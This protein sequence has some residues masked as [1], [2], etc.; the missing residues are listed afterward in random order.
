MRMKRPTKTN[1]KKVSAA[2]E[3]STALV[4]S[5]EIA[6]LIKRVVAIIEEAQTRVVRVVNST[7]VLAYWSIGREI[8]EFVQ[9]GSA[10]AEYG[11][12]VLEGLASRLRKRV[13]RGYSIRNL[14]NFRRFYQAFSD[15][16]PSIHDDR[17]FGRRRLPN[18]LTGSSSK[19]EIRQMPSAES[20]SMLTR[21]GFS[22][23]LS[24]S[25]YLALSKVSDRAARAF[26]EIEAARES[27]S[28]DH[29]ERQIH[30]RLHLRLL[31]SMFDSLLRESIRRLGARVPAHVRKVRLHGLLALR[32]SLDSL[33]TAVEHALRVATRKAFLRSLEKARPSSARSI[34]SSRLSSSTSSTCLKA[35]PCTKAIS[36]RRSSAS[37]RT[38]SLSSGKG[39][40]SSHA[41]SVSSSKTRS[42]TSTSFSTT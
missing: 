38:S 12:Q 37:S 40:R 31:K 2:R 32:P 4:S 8:V 13:G 30:T 36:K 5:R 29:L 14:R 1:P 33:A 17:R 35:R 3:R 18:L 16:S 28:V 25:H 21:T 6:P 27:W 22:N 15:R 42:S 7:M 34:S 26:Y 39:L 19:K 41:R 9:S 20:L 10:R 11:E 23:R 24:W